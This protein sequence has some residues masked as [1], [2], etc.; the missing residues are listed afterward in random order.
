VDV[1]VDAD[2]D[3]DVDVDLDVDKAYSVEDTLRD[4]REIPCISIGYI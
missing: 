1:D 3:V 2:V 4:G